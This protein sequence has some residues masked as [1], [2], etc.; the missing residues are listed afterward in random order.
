MCRI[1]NLTSWITPMF[2]RFVLF[3]DPWCPFCRRV[4]NFLDLNQY[5]LPMR[6]VAQDQEAYR[7][8]VEGGGRGTVPCLRI[9]ENNG[10]IRWLYESID[11]IEFIQGELAA[12]SLFI[13]DLVTNQGRWQSSEKSPA[14][15]NFDRSCL[16]AFKFWEIKNFCEHVGW[17]ART[18][19][20]MRKKSET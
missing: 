11:I 15:Y 2:N 5:S 14:W 20:C 7:E 19:E 4:T 9:I 18:T 3:Q 10:S 1:L 12:W 16:T 17:R 13:N 6:D 8:L